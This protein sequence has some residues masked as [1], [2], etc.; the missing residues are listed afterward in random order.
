MVTEALQ[1]FHGEGLPEVDAA[2]IEDI[3]DLLDL[4]TTGDSGRR[5]AQQRLADQDPA[6]VTSAMLRIVE[7]R[8]AE[9]YLR[10]EAY[11]WLRE[12]GVAAMVPRLTLRLKYEKDWVANVEITIGLLRYGCGAGL[13]PMVTILRTEEGIPDLE[14]ARWAAV[15][16]LTLLPP[17]PGWTPGEDFDEDWQ[18]LLEVEEAWLRARIL[19]GATAPA[20]PSR[21]L[22][23]EVWKT[24]AKF[25][26]Q[27]LRPVDDARY[28]LTRLPSWVFGP[29]C[30]TTYDEDRYVREHA[31]QTLAWSGATVGRWAQATHF[32][33]A[34]TL[35]PLLADTRQRSRV[36]EA[37]GASGLPTMQQ[38][39]LPWLQ[40][41]GLEE[42]TAAADAL[43]RSADQDLLRPI[44]ALLSSDAALGPE[45][46]YS[47]ELLRSRL[48]A[49]Y[50][51]AIPAGL[52]PSERAR[53]DRWASA[54]D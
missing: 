11:A 29:L 35:T 27:P 54:R 41:G 10:S 3:L 22:R 24:L 44:V 5:R 33:L 40:Q 17:A 52:D 8:D 23:A 42:S 2:G 36:L 47:L 13:E 51:P 32:D 7:G 28:V 25:R 37:M 30:E 48:D 50:T 46:R 12:F 38:A 20:Q 53:R 19:P 39:L 34:A 1:E 15:S 31:L 26:S 45:G 16:A 4:G 21:A 18:R 49:T 14:R 43:L 6:M 9:P